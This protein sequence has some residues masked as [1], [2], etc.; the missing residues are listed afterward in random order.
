MSTTE[1]A[2][3][4]QQ[5]SHLFEPIRIGPVE[6]P[7]RLFFSPHMV[8]H[9]TAPDPD[10]PGFG[11]PNDTLKEYYAERA[12]G[13]VGLIIQGATVV[14]RSSMAGMLRAFDDTA[15]P[16]FRPIT[17][18]VHEHG[19]KIFMQLMHGGAHADPEGMFGGAITP[20]AIPDSAAHL[21]RSPV[22]P[23]TRAEIRETAAAWAL[24][25]ANSLEAGYDGVEIHGSHNY[26]VAEFLS[27]F[28]NHRDD[29]YGGSLDNRMRFLFEL[30]EGMRDSMG[31]RGALGVRIIADEAWPGALTNND[32]VEIAG[33]LD[34]WGVDFLNIG[35]V[36]MNNHDFSDLT[37]PLLQGNDRAI[38]A[39]RNM[40]GAI[41][42]AVVLGVPTRLETPDVGEAL[43]AGG[44]LDMVGAART[45]MADPEFGRKAQ[46]GRPEDIRPCIGLN[47]CL[48]TGY[49]AVNPTMQ[50]EVTWPVYPPAAATSRRVVVVGGGPG[51]LEAAR[52]ASLRGH[53]V[54]L[55]ERNEALGGALN[56]LG[57]LP[58]RGRAN[59]A[60][61]WW[62]RQLAVQGVD[63]RVGADATA[64]AVLAHHP[65][66]VVVATGARWDPT[67]STA[68]ASAAIPGSGQDFVITPDDVFAGKL[69][70][71]GRVVLLDEDG[72]T[73]GVGVAEFLA[74][75]GMPVV[76]IT[77]WP[78]VAPFLDLS[79][80][81]TK[82]VRRLRQLGVEMMAESYVRSIGDHSVVAFDMLLPAEETVIEDVAIV[83]LVTRQ[84]PLVGLAD[85]LR[86]QVPELHVIGDAKHPRLV[87]DAT[88]DGYRIGLAI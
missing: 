5:F 3:T 77:R 35:P 33:R 86:G 76:L 62:A 49:C 65:D 83:V 61:A 51:G 71:A 26:L 66:V 30:L 38:E 17:D 27:P 84:I 88:A 18:A 9:G 74:E 28:Y 42:K 23:M 8:L 21:F 4:D 7:N 12:R 2:G 53:Q 45:F 72:R 32:M 22:R 44:T 69:P 19:G 57:A 40:R 63:V 37:P 14:Q 46:E 85:D 43:V 59:A 16:G 79:R 48:E 75:R 81:R 25:A 36:G 1:Q 24:C 20:S 34:E 67:G 54:T 87:A 10:M 47:S 13:G 64:E 82:S 52:V 56:E 70:P 58:R 41:S 68:I 11:L 29:E 15:V 80:Q 50:R 31:G 55:F 39:M 73:T 6:I 78:E 60:G